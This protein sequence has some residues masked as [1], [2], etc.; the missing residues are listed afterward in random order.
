MPLAD[1]NV[2]LAL[3]LSKH[4]FHR[5]ARTWLKQQSSPNPALFCRAT[6]QTV[7]RLLTT[8]A[9]LAP[10]G[11]PPLSNKAACSVCEGF[12]AD[13]R[14]AWGEEARGLESSWKNLAAGSQASPKLWMDAYLAA[15]AIA[16]K[17]QLVTTDKAFRQFKDLDVLVLDKIS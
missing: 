14:V 13:E 7:L 9:V 8:K 6:Q 5:S 17:Q 15:F 3:A 12:L 2:W 11:L 1:S 10:Y 16:A 4:E